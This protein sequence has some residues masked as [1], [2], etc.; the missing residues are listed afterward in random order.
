MDDEVTKR[1]PYCDHL[2]VTLLLQNGLG[3]STYIVDLCF[4]SFVTTTGVGDVM[5][6]P[7]FFIGLNEKTK[8][9]VRR[10]SSNETVFADLPL[11]IIGDPLHETFAVG[12]MVL[13]VS[14]LNRF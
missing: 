8:L 7:P 11:P 9:D 10:W 4:G 14:S 12:R 13:L 5:F 6:L 1:N 3:P 2:P